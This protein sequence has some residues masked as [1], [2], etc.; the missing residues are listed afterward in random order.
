MWVTSFY[1]SPKS[2]VFFPPSSHILWDR[3]FCVLSTF[4]QSWGHDHI[5]S[6][7]H[8]RALYSFEIKE[9]VN[10]I[11]SEGYGHHQESSVLSFPLSL[12]YSVYFFGCLFERL[13]H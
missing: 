11:I 13:Y 4:L 9:K 12:E 2:V 3:L 6:F 5:P 10:Y 1:L 7:E 8:S